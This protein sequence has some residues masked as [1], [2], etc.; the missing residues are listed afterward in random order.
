[1]DEPPRW[2]IE[3]L[4]R[5]AAAALANG[6]GGSGGVRAAAASRGRDLPDARVVRWYASIGLVDRPVGGRG[7]GARYGARHLRQL[8]AVKRLQA[9]GWSLADIQA[10]L[11]GA[12]DDALRL[13]APVPE[14]VLAGELTHQA[15]GSEAA[16]AAPAAAP[17]APPAAP[18]AARSVDRFWAAPVP[19]AVE[20]TAARHGAVSPVAGLPAAPPGGSPRVVPLAGVELADGVLLVLPRPPADTDLPA[21]AEAAGPLLA[22]L[23]ALGLTPSPSPSADLT[24]GAPR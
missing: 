15:A 21:L 6:D 19:P 4:T 16:V 3:E 13:L 12:D 10:R 17:P 5:R 2:T 8:V 9:E 18:A 22:V 14:Q 1:M 24:P 23:H 11:A 20:V 7:R